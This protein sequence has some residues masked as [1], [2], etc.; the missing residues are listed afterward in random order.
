MRNE[1]GFERP[2]R[3]TVDGRSFVCV[4]EPDSL[5]TVAIAKV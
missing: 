2:V 1:A 4:M 3:V 5:N